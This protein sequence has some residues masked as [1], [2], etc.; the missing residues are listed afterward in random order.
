MN[1]KL[2][3]V[4]A[5]LGILVAA[6]ACAFAVGASDRPAALKALERQGVS[7][8]GT[9]PAP[10]GLTAWAA[11]E[12]QRPIALYV[13]PDGKHV[14]AGTLLDAQAR[15]VAQPALESAVSRSMTA[16]VWRRL[17]SS[18]WIE[19][20]RKDAPRTVYVFTDPECPYCSKFWSDARPWV[21]SGQVKL[22]HVM[23]GVVKP[24]SAGKAAALLASSNPAEALAAYEGAR[25]KQPRSAGARLE[26]MT[27]IPPD[28]QARIDANESL[29]ASLGLRATPAMAWRDAAGKVQM[30]TGASPEALPLIAGLR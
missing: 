20:G 1:V 27:A 5:A 15:E 29:M 26:P 9:F 6:G 16:D 19:D 11:Y 23:V 25:S 21:D 22:R 7:I 2:S 13:T 4:L 3:S 18:H 24:S 17:E 8:V 12:G 28:L 10:G 30:R 14:I